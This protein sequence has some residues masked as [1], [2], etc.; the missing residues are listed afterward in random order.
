MVLDA[1]R[2]LPYGLPHENARNWDGDDAPFGYEQFCAELDRAKSM[3][4]VEVEE[5]ILRLGVRE[6]EWLA[7]FLGV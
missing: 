4:P 2:G 5:K 1:G 6:V 3:L 7:V